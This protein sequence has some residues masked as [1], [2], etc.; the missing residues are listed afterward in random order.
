MPQ[1]EDLAAEPKNDLCNRIPLVIRN[2]TACTLNPTRPPCPVQGGPE[3]ECP[4]CLGPVADPSQLTTLP[5]DH[6]FHDDCIRTWT[7]VYDWEDYDVDCAHCPVCYLDLTY[8]CGDMISADLLRPGVKILPQELELTCPSYHALDRDDD[9]DDD[10]HFLKFS[11]R[12]CSPR[13]VADLW[14]VQHAHY[15]DQ[16]DALNHRQRHICQ[17]FYPDIWLPPPPPPTRPAPR[18]HY[19]CPPSWYTQAPPAQPPSNQAPLLPAV[20]R[21][22]RIDDQPPTPPPSSASSPPSSTY[23]HDTT[24]CEASLNP[25]DHKHQRKRRP[26]PFA[27]RLA[28]ACL[29]PPGAGSLSLPGAA[30]IAPHTAEGWR[31]SAVRLALALDRGDAR[32]AWAALADLEGMGFRFLVFWPAA[33]PSL[34]PLDAARARLRGLLRELLARLGRYRR[35]HEGWVE[36]NG[37][38]QMHCEGEREALEKAFAVFWSLYRWT[39]EQTGLLLKEFTY[40]RG[41]W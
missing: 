27:F 3:D 32:F 2:G 25:A 13:N 10:Q 21:P 17:D 24:C 33:Q 11:E 7:Q 18:L 15:T 41:V 4:L 26:S 1:E 23:P 39:R 22:L 29:R 6:A 38:A 19:P 20:W 37:V 40:A 30:R 35:E 31:Y 9:D 8:R 36:L 14:F 28:N 5:C 12:P 34:A 16:L